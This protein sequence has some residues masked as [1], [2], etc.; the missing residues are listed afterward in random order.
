MA[1]KEGTRVQ[2]PTYTDHGARGDRFGVVIGNDKLFTGDN[3]IERVTVVL[4]KSGK[5]A[6]FEADDCTEVE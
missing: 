1:I 4:D 5:A 3:V 2:V 6:R